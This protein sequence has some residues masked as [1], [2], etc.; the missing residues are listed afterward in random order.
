MKDKREIGLVCLTQQPNKSL[1][2]VRIKVRF[3]R[4]L[5]LTRNSPHLLHLKTPK[6]QPYKRLAPE[7]GIDWLEKQNMSVAKR[8]EDI[9]LGW[10]PNRITTS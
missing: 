2:I 1:I 9:M 5:F 3:F 10:I 4:L 8:T 7:N 6:A